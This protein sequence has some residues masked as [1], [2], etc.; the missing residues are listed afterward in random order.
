MFGWRAFAMGLNHVICE[1]NADFL[2][3]ALIFILR[4]F[5]WRAR[6][7]LQSQRARRLT[8]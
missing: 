1:Q 8:F 2:H 5:G 3:F 7:L 4:F 6:A